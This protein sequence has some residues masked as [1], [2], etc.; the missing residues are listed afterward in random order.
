LGACRGYL[1]PF[2]HHFPVT[3]LVLPEFC[4]YYSAAFLNTFSM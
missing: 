1:Y 4:S 2:Y 3:E